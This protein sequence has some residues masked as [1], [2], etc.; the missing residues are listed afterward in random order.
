MVKIKEIAFEALL[1]N[2]LK[3]QGRA[4][5]KETPSN[6]TLDGEVVANV[7]EAD[8]VCI[9]DKIGRYDAA[10]SSG[11]VAYMKNYL[12]QPPARARKKRQQGQCWHI[13]GFQSY[14]SPLTACP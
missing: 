9:K 5:N 7:R 3:Q 4:L 14:T 1:A 6:V 13:I 11:L 10:S 2:I 8:W 12:A